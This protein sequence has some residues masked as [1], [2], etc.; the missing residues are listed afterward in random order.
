M[1][2]PAQSLWGRGG[3]TEGF[4]GCREQEWVGAL[5]LS[6][7]MVERA[8]AEQRLVPAGERVES[9]KGQSCVGTRE[10][11]KVPVL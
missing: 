7:S 6:L 11:L 1:H 3:K 2:R 5:K 8:S 10:P 9:L 4:L